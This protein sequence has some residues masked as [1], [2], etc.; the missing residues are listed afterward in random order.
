MLFRSHQGAVALQLDV[1]CEVHDAAE[2]DR[3]L[4]AGCDIIG[5]NNRN[6]HTFHVDLNTSL[7][8]AT[9]I[10]AGVLK[11]AESGIESEDDIARLRG[12]GFDAFLIGESLMRAKRP[13]DALRT[14][15]GQKA[16]RTN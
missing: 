5:V 11:V 9:R 8:L 7:Q 6:L 2:L 10:P 15:L 4:D 3:A 14:L 13:G 1:L 16:I 12:A